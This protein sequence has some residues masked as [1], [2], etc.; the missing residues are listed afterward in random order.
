MNCFAV[1]WLRGDSLS[2]LR[3]DPTPFVPCMPSVLL[4]LAYVSC[5][6]LIRCK[7]FSSNV[8]SMECRDVHFTQSHL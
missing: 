1:M 8:N 7:S 5:L 2:F 3:H 6:N 4:G